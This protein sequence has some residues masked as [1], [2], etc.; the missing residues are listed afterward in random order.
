MKVENNEIQRLA[1]RP[2][3]LANPYDHTES[4]SEKE[5]DMAT[6]IRIL[7]G[8]FAL[9]VMAFLLTGTTAH[10]IPASG[11]H[12]VASVSAA[13]PAGHGQGTP[14]PTPTPTCGCH[15]TPPPTPTPTPTCGCH[16]TPPPTPTPTPPTPTP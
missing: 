3:C 16:S 10:A 13:S 12:A 8:C 9:G 6:R 15:S 2:L 4:S 7:A 5:R 11:A 1:G 14:T